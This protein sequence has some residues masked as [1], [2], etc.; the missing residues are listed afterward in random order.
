MRLAVKYAFL[1]I[2]LAL[3]LPLALLCLFGRVR[4]LFSTGAH[5]V[6]LIPGL[7]GDYIRICFYYWTLRACSLKSRISFGSFFA[8]PE[9]ELAA[10]VYIGSY[11]V[12][13]RTRIG[14]RTQIAGGVQ[15][16]SGARQ[17][18]RNDEGQIEGAEAGVFETISIGADCWIGAAAIVMAPVGEGSTIGA[19]SI[20]TREIPARSVAFGNPARVKA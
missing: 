11:S 8:H 4:A 17:H 6:A 10:G 12:L 1:G 14:A 9:A 19:G 16:L 18:T 3:S 5:A 15:I 7:P 20:V 2:G 13:G